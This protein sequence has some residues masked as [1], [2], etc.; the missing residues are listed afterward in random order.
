[1]TQRSK[2][3]AVLDVRVSPQFLRD[4]HSAGVGL[5]HLAERK[6][7]DLQRRADADPGG[8]RRG[9][10]RVE[11]LK[12]RA[13]VLEIDLAGGPRLLAID[14][15]KALV[16]W[17]MGDHEV[18]TR[19]KTSH[20]PDL[21]EST[22]APSLFSPAAR[23]PFFPTNEDQGF[24]IYGP[25]LLRE[26]VYWLDEEQQC[27]GTTIEH[28]VT[29]AVLE[30][31]GSID[32]VV[33]GPGT[34][35]TT[36]LLWL[37]KS[38]SSVEND[39]AGLEVRFNGPVS[40]V[41]QLE[42]GT[43]W[44]L[45]SLRLPQG[46][47]QGPP[48][49]IV[50]MDDPASLADI[51]E[52]SQRFPRSS[53]IAGFDPLQM[54]AS[55]TDADLATWIKKTSAHVSWLAVSYRQKEVVGQFAKRVAEIVAQS[56]P[57]LAEAKKVAYTSERHD[58]TKRCNDLTFA[59]PTG[60]IRTI[61]HPTLED[62]EAYWQRL[63]RLQ[64]TR[65]LWTYWPPLIVVTDPK[66]LLPA[67]WLMRID[68]IPSHRRTTNELPQVKGLEYQHVLMLLSEQTFA[69]LNSG[70]TGSGQRSYDLIRLYRIPFS[71]A[72]DS[73]VTFVFRGQDEQD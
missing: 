32:V 41:N 2:A 40:V 59:N 58:L 8:W 67:G 65:E 6:I 69:A 16:L 71:R 29:D 34:G 38:L 46:I 22:E 54:T 15:A 10:D 3:G 11:G 60:M 23:L 9:Y 61:E 26:W 21:D 70:F 47:L 1:M 37:L 25:E 63:Y 42:N 66:A 72:K 20:V 30:Q 62:W 50:L 48:P 43:G 4:Y 27:V 45:T 44:D 73:L 31:R 17:R 64:R 19:A 56:S 12:G 57:F 49:D 55:I 68:R 39:G 7:Q 51:T 24:S 36:L 14:Y 33:G 28:R 35:K 52:M 53:I 13:E 18:T 5:Q